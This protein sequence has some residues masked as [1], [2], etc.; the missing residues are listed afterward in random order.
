M[1]R[2]S[3]VRELDLLG[4]APRFSQHD[5]GLDEV[6]NRRYLGKNEDN[7]EKVMRTYNDSSQRGKKRR[8]R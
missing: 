3:L 1:L 4:R 6:V 2:S 8:N 7:A 5:R